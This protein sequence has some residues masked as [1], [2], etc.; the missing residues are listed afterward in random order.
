MK[1]PSVFLV[2]VLVALSS[3]LACAE[4]YKVG[5]VVK[6]FSAKDQF[7]RPY[8]FK[9]GVKFLLVSFDMETGKAANGALAKLGGKYLNEKGAVYMANIHGMPGVGRMFALPKMRKY[10]HAIVLADEENLL[11]DYPRKEG[12]VTVL[13]LDGEARI[14]A[15]SYW[16]PGSEKLDDLLK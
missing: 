4:T 6:S 11:A 3:L 14:A 13:K 16:S 15:I 9:K 8:T 1:V 7:E 5:S 2:S 12:K 10:P